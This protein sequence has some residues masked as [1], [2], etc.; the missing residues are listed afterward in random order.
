MH[1][2][3]AHLTPRTRQQALDRLWPSDGYLRQKRLSD[4]KYVIF[5]HGM[6]TSHVLGAELVVKVLYQAICELSFLPTIAWLT[7]VTTWCSFLNC[8]C[9]GA[10]SVLA[11][12][13]CTA[14]VLQMCTCR[15]S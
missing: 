11:S 5:F 6:Q 2:H 15:A 9:A 3:A 13:V 8:C 7:T 10:K 12:N 4:D 1:T 14:V